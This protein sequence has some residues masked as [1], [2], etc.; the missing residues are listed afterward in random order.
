MAVEPVTLRDLGPRDV[1]LKVTA[2]NACVTDAIVLAPDVPP[3]FGNVAPQIFG[4]GAVGI[5]EKVGSHVTV[6]IV[7]AAFDHV[8]SFMAQPKSPPPGVCPLTL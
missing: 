6:T 4:H 5:I 1:L 7:S 2:A 3:M 8:D